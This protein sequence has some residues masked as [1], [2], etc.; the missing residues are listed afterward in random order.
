MA[1]IYPEY[2]Y[3][4]ADG[5]IEALEQYRADGIVALVREK[6]AKEPGPEI[7]REAGEKSGTVAVEAG[8]KHQD[9]TGEMIETAAARTG[10]AFPSLMQRYMEIWILCTGLSE[11]W[12]LKQATPRGIVYEIAHCALGERVSREWPGSGN[13]ACT[14]YCIGALETI[15][16]ELGMNLEVKREDPDSGQ[17]LCRFVIAPKV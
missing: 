2:S 14:G 7:F 3:D 12:L 8:K 16:R 4:L 15:A 11:K 10:M 9:R 6:S 5:I 1:K 17:G 13:A